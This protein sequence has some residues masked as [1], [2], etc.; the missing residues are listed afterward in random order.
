MGRQFA[1][2]MYT[3]LYCLLMVFWEGLR[4]L[5]CAP[6]QQHRATLCTIDLHCA[7]S[8][9]VVHH[10]AEAGPN[11]LRSSWRPNIFHILVV[12][13]EHTEMGHFLSIF[14]S[15]KLTYIIHF[16]RHV[17]PPT[18]CAGHMLI[19]AF[20]LH[21]T[22]LPAIFKVGTRLHS[23]GRCFQSSWGSLV[24]CLQWQNCLLLIS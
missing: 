7:P 2:D 3:P 11:L 21:Y 20:W 13:M 5:C 24:C 1:Y 12:H 8:T 17:A 14:W 18:W 4:G 6:L 23:G 15:V 10:G 16:V 19:L 9:C 22:W